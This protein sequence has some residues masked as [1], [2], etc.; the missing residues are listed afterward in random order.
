MPFPCLSTPSGPQQPRAL[1]KPFTMPLSAYK[2]YLL[3][4]VAKL[5]AANSAGHTLKGRTSRSVHTFGGLHLGT[6][7]PSLDRS[8]GC[9][10]KR[11]DWTAQ[12]T[13]RRHQNPS[14]CAKVR[15]DL[16]LAGNA[17]YSPAMGALASAPLA[18][19]GGPATLSAL[20]D[21]QSWPFSPL[22]PLPSESLLDAPP[23]FQMRRRLLS[24]WIP[25]L[26]PAQTACR[27]GLSD[28]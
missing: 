15:R 1:R 12:Q 26:H 27:L 4:F 14:Q 23:P 8:H 28:Y 24:L 20:Y 9:S 21:L 2:F 10:Q 18:N 25:L 17:H 19:L 5:S 7:G 6:M 22:T 16:R 13:R 11:S 3:P